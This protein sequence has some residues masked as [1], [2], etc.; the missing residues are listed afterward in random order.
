[1]S[2]IKVKHPAVDMLGKIFEMSNDT[3]IPF[4]EIFT[5]L[6]NLVCSVNF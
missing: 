3:S 5:S 6:I 1:M 2:L 4:Q